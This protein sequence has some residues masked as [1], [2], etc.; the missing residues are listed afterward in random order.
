M[1]P[2][3]H[4]EPVTNKLLGEKLSLLSINYLIVLTRPMLEVFMTVL[5]ALW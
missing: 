4:I 2:L 5:N 1:K 3:V